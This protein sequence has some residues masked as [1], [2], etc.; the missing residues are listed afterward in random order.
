[1]VIP[2][3]FT[4]SGCAVAVKRLIAGNEAGAIHAIANTAYG[5][6]GTTGAFLL[7]VVLAPYLQERSV[8][9]LHGTLA[10]L[11]WLVVTDLLYYAWHRA[12][13]AWPVLWAIHRLHHE[14]TDFNPTTYYRQHPLEAAAQLITVSIP[15]AMFLPFTLTPFVALGFSVAQFLFQSWIHSER[16]V[17]APTR[18]SAPARLLLK[19]VATPW[20]HRLH[21]STL[22]QHANRN[23]AGNLPVIDILFGT[24]VDPAQNTAPYSIGLPLTAEAILRQSFEPD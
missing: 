13:H 12:Q 15:M 21:H 22:P 6:C 16:D 20:S 23:F 18:W 14:D 1:M 24:F 7:W 19:F 9:A 4:V 3:L 5:V 10:T 2:L 11:A 8:P 17:S